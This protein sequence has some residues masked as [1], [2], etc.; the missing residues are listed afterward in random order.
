MRLH[1]DDD[2]ASALLVR[3][4]R[5]SG[6]D[7][8]TPA[9]LGI[10]GADDPIHLTCAIREDCVLLSGNHDDFE[11]LHDLV[12]QARGHHPGVFVVRRDN[13]V[14]RDLTH[15]GIVRAIRNLLAAGVALADR[16][17]VLNHW[18]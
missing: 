14:R 3:L 10:A 8:W 1:L 13:D 12:M 6:H 5:Q 17:Y 9:D 7:V 18:R 11:A 15:A 2:L 16:L 4:L